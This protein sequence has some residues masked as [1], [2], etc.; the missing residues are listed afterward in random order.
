MQTFD[1]RKSTYSGDGSNC[2]EIATTPGTVL[3]RDSKNPA[4][5]HLAL[6]PAAWADF[7]SHLTDA[8]R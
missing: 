6:P 8:D 4:G 7:L 3:V 2:V 1:W 5:P